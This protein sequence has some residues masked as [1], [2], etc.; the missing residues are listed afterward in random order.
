MIS[1]PAGPKFQFPAD[2]VL[3]KITPQTRLIAIAN[4][5]NPTGIVAQP[6]ELLRIACAVPTAAVLVD[7]AYFEFYGQT[8]IPHCSELPN[9]FVAR[10]FSKA[11]GMAGLRLGA[12]AGPAQQMQAVRRV[13]SPYNVNA[14]AL[15]CLPEALADQSFVKDYVQEVSQARATVEDILRASGVDFWP[16]KANFVLVRVGTDSAASVAFVEYMRKRG[17]LVRDRS[18]DQGCG[19]CVRITLGPRVHTDR[20]L[21]ALQAALKDLCLMQGVSRR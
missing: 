2:D 16:S 3:N 20:L 4:P 10:T 19:G 5:N 8:L 15:A 13:S 21:T 12:L 1:V 7:E 17:I 6:Q 11:Y 9:L 14:V 18:S